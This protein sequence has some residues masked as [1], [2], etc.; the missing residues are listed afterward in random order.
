VRSLLHM[1][2]N[3]LVGVDRA[4]EAVCLRLARQAAVTWRATQAG[5][6]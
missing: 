2:H 1:H 4:R 5:R 3:R 6:A